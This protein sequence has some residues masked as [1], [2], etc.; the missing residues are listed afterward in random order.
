MQQEERNYLDARKKELKG[1]K[2]PSKKHAQPIVHKD[3]ET[4]KVIY[5]EE[6]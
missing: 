6:Q 1:R 4:G 3:K 5:R 2:K